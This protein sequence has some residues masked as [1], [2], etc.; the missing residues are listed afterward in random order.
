MTPLMLPD[1]HLSVTDEDTSEP[2]VMAHGLGGTTQSAC[3]T[4]PS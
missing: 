2:V 4:G 1:K 3:S